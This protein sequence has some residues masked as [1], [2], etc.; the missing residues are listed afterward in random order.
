MVV[1]FE[2]GG[3]EDYLHGVGLMSGSK[4]ESMLRRAEMEKSVDNGSV[5]GSSEE[6][7]SGWWGMNMFISASKC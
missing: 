1:R 6:E 5:I 4:M 2:V 3:I 7:W